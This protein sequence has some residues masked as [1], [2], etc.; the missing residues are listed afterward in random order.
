MVELVV[1]TF[2]GGEAKWNIIIGT[3]VLLLVTAM[4][5]IGA[6]SYGKINRFLWGGQL[7][8]IWI[9]FACILFTKGG[10]VLVSHSWG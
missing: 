2:F 4:A 1:E 5:M 7:L 8:T 3:G 9:T 6:E 10:S